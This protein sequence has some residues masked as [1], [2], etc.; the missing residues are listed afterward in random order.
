MFRDSSILISRF[1]EFAIS[2]CRDFGC[3]IPRVRFRDFA[4]SVFTP[5]AA[6]LYRARST[7]ILVSHLSAAKPGA[8]AFLICPRTS[9]VLGPEAPTE[10]TATCTAWS[11]CNQVGRRRNW[12]QTTHGR[13]SCVCPPRGA[14][15]N[16]ASSVIHLSNSVR[17]PAIDEQRIPMRPVR[18]IARLYFHNGPPFKP[19]SCMFH[20]ETHL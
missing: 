1:R 16:T 14:I 19:G 8:G 18:T 15:F 17:A 2:Q 20:T 10:T 6:P 12:K 11:N 5:R 7:E 3:A 4:I 9:L 13:P